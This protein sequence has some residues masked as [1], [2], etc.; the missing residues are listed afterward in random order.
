MA[1]ENTPKKK[2]KD[3]WLK[4]IDPDLFRGFKAWC[5][6]R[7]LSIKEKILSLMRETIGKRGIGRD[8]GRSQSDRNDPPPHARNLDLQMPQE[9]GSMENAPSEVEESP[10]MPPEQGRAVREGKVLLGSRRD[11][12]STRIKAMDD[13]GRIFRVE[14][15]GTCESDT[16]TDLRGLCLA[17]PA[18]LK[19]TETGNVRGGTK[20]RF[21]QDVPTDADAVLFR[22]IVVVRILSPEDL[23][24]LLCG[25]ESPQSQTAAS[26]L[27]PEAKATIDEIAGKVVAGED[28][29]RLRWGLGRKRVRVLI[30]RAFPDRGV[31]GPLLHRTLE[32]RMKSVGWVQAPNTVLHTYERC[33][34]PG[35]GPGTQQGLARLRSNPPPHA[36]ELDLQMTQE[37]SPVENT[38][39]EVEESPS[40][41]PEQQ[42]AMRNGTEVSQAQMLQLLLC[43]QLKE[44]KGSETEVGESQPANTVGS[45]LPISPAAVN[46]AAFLLGAGERIGQ[47]LQCNQKRP[48]PD[49]QL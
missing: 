6:L 44:E 41:P 33:G 36:P 19:N 11:A 48:T 31:R 45:S 46:M 4:D 42:P 9:D 23:A 43:E 21:D 34:A 1:E 15:V 17:Q 16:L 10:S 20:V 40:M 27:A 26:E 39:S 2:T 47:F 3:M 12:A 49:K 8:A 13:C 5:S 29:P 32:D 35:L 28:D 18:L 14:L 38:P 7:G 22:S 37:E 30:K 25:P 24:T